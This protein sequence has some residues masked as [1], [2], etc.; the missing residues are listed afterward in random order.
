M[1]AENLCM[2]FGPIKAVQNASFE[3]GQGEVVGLL[4]PNGA[5]KTTTMRILTTYLT[6]SS[7]SVKI[8]G[9]NI[10][11]KP[12]QARKKIGYLPEIAPLYLEMEVHEYLSFVGKSRG[13]YGKNLKQNLS[14]IQESCQIKPVWKQPIYELSKGYRQ[15]VGLAQA[16]VHDPEILILDEPTSGLDPLQILGIRDLIKELSKTKTILFSTHIL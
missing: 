8:F 12:I 16:L 6:P 13:L 4:G 11:A 10:N 9:F 5:G 7:G 14:S 3:I 15:R 2:S 1:S